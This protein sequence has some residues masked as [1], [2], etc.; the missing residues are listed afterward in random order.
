MTDIDTR[1]DRGIEKQK[2]KRNGNGKG[3]DTEQLLAEMNERYCVV[4]DG[5]RARVLTFDRFT[6]QVGR[7]KYERHIP[8]FLTFEDFRNLHLHKHVRISEDK[9]MPLGHWWLKNIGRRQYDG[10]IFQ[11]NGEAI[12]DNRL[13]L[14]RGWG[15]EVKQGDWSLMREHIRT[16]L[17]SGDDEVYVYIINWMAWTVQHPNEQAEV[18][19]VF[20]GKPGTG[21]GTLGNALCRMFGQHAVHISSAV[22]LAG[23]FNMH[24]RDC[25]LLFADEAFWP[26][27]KSAE[28]TLKR[29]LTEPDLFIEP[30]GRDGITV[31]NML[32]VM[33][34]SNEDW[35]VPAGEHERR[36]G[37]FD[38]DPCHLQDEAWFGPLYEQL[39]TSGYS[40]ML[41]DLLRHKLPAGWHPRR[42]PRTSALVDQQRRSLDAYD[43]WWVELLEGGVL[44]GA[45]VGNPASAISNTYELTKID[46]FGG[47]RIIKRNGLYDQARTIEPRL[48]ARSDHLLGA[49]LRDQ[50]CKTSRPSRRRG[51]TFP[52]LAKCR[53]EWLKRFPDW[54]WHDGVAAFAQWR[55]E[56][57]V[58]VVNNVEEE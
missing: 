28:G 24:L 39:E 26:G 3:S 2:R 25:C 13:N 55:F 52:P 21:K 36:Y 53:N 15:V 58:V 43:A 42:L 51:W 46:N 5:G 11:P 19:L 38:V 56:S 14:W 44:E 17:A 37:C 4:L 49:Y 32:H 31:Q 27:D 20:R 48:K 8:T 35:T 6:R 16:V 33:M 45:S 9:S 57:P 18:A 22:H 1:I 34:A 47:Q 12:V 10:V 50:G 54:K 23:R 29:I 41:Y 7:F 30:K 40:G